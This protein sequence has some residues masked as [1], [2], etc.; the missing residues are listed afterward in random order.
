MG[1]SGTSGKMGPAL[2][3]DTGRAAPR[4]QGSMEIEECGKPKGHLSTINPAVGWKLS[5]NRTEVEA[6]S[7]TQTCILRI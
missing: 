7:N 5:L 6:A 2:R 3:R 4:K 1:G